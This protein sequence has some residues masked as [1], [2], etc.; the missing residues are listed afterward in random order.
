MLSYRAIK[1]KR[2]NVSFCP[3]NEYSESDEAVFLSL[4]SVLKDILSTDA[5][6]QG[7]KEQ[8]DGERT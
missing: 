8:T 3:E 1:G 6:D 5:V 7:K 2:M 4:P